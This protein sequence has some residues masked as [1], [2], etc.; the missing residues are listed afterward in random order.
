MLNFFDIATHGWLSDDD[1]IKGQF[2]ENGCLSCVVHAYD[3]YL[4][5]LVAVAHLLKFANQLGQI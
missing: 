4:V 2:V 1:F 5:L 3:D